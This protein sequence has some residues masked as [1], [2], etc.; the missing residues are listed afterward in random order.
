MTWPPGSPDD[1]HPDDESGPLVRMFAMTRGRTRHPRARFDLIAIVTASGEVPDRMARL[2][3]E[4][5][6]ILR[7]CGSPQSVA[8]ICSTLDLP[9]GVLR[10]LLGDLVEQKLISVHAPARNS[11]APNEYVL[12]EVIEGIRAL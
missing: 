8:E 5:A 9:L 4:H 1:D 12:R 11:Q 2:G 3:P 6:E 10:V 7:V